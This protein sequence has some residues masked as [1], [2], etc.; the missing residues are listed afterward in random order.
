MAGIATRG[1][2]YFTDRDLG[3]QFPARL[4]EAGLVVERHADHFAHDTPDAQWLT[5]VGE[6]GWIV[7]T[8]DERI[9]YKANELAA[10]IEHRIAMLLVVGHAPHA[11]LAEHFVQTIARIDAFVATHQPPYIAKVYRPTPKELAL[12][13][14]APGSVVHWYPPAR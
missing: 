6:R 10:V 2:V 4:R 7:V 13:P 1:P 11:Q 9:R 3:K 5:A 14:D 12:R 8:H